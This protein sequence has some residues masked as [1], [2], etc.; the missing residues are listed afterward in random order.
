MLASGLVGIAAIA[1]VLL[2]VVGAFA[3]RKRKRHL[4]SNADGSAY[5]PDGVNDGDG[6]SDG[7]C[8][9][10]GGDGGGGGGGGD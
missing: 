9:G 3:E 6:G 4:A 10:G 2:V 5:M 1:M 7:G 8:D